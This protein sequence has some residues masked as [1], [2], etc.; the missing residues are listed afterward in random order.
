MQIAYYEENNYHTEIMGTFL[1]YLKSINANITVYNTSDKSSTVSYYQKF[2]NFSLKP[3]TAI[4]N[5]YSIFDKIIIG[6]AADTKDF[7]DKLNIINYDKL[8]FVCHH[9]NDI[10]K[11]YKNVIIL[12]PLNYLPNLNPNIKYILPIHDFINYKNLNTKKQKN[13]LTIIGRF[14]DTN[15]DTNDLIHL[16]KNYN[17]L[18]F[19]VRIFSRVKKMVPK[20]LFSLAEEYPSKLQIFLKTSSLKMDTYLKESKYILPLVSKNSW[21]H[22]DRLSGNIALAYNYKIPLIIDSTLQKIYSIENCIV[23]NNSLAEIIHNITNISDVDY[24]TMVLNFIKCQ[25]N[26]IKNNNEILNSIINL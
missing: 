9:P 16:I 2:C 15:R 25:Q 8:I 1:Q 17:K 22:K 11:I 14:K 5:D 6:S 10:K 3:H 23:Y 13:I 7:V 4:I 21:Y 20:I 24:E 19:T 18:D 26:I 12:T